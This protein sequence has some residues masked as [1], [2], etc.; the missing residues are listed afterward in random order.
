[1]SN[2]KDKTEHLALLSVGDLHD[3]GCICRHEFKR[4]SPC[5]YRKNGFDITH[6]RESMYNDKKPKIDEKNKKK[7]MRDIYKEVFLSAGEPMVQ[8]NKWM[9]RFKGAMKR[10]HDNSE[11]WNVGVS[12]Y[13]DMGENFLPKDHGGAGWWYPYMHNWHHL[14]PSGATYDYIVGEDGE[15]GVWRLICLMLA[16]YNINC[17]ENII[18]L[19]KERFV[20]RALGLP[21]H[22]PYNASGHRD[23]SGACEGRLTQ[24]RNT[25]NEAITE[26]ECSIDISKC[27]AAKEAMMALSNSLLN[28]IKNMYGGQSIEVISQS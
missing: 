22:T 11:A 13:S 3:R 7:A 8:L 28:I 10:L 20:G 15:N 19:P 14:I 25:L 9:R 23:Y 6:S 5:D 26:E 4:G 17:K 24:I 18:L 21:V 2:K 12:C 1:M 27:D 16:E